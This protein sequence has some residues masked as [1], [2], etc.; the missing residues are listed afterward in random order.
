M[1]NIG[2]VQRNCT[3]EKAGG[4]ALRLAL[5]TNFQKRGG[6]VSPGPPAL[7]P[8]IM[9]VWCHSFIILNDFFFTKP[10]FYQCYSEILHFPIRMYSIKISLN[11][12][13]TS[14]KIEHRNCGI[15]AYKIF[16]NIRT[17]ST[18]Q[19]TFSLWYDCKN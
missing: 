13:E 2:G 14:S 16:D 9:I 5:L 4:G 6:T 3:L 10:T 8:L 11:I 12:K 17:L 15:V 7:P 1:S 19:A 18:Y